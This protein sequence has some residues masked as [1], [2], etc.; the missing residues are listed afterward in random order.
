[1]KILNKITE[2]LA[3]KKSKAVDDFIKEVIPNWQLNLIY[4]SKSK[5]LSLLLGWSFSYEI[6]PGEFIDKVIIYRWNRP[7]KTLIITTNIK[8]DI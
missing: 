2:K 7:V 5:L 4:K 6:V 1:M 3:Y 8:Y